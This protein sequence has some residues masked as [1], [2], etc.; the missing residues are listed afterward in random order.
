MVIDTQS[1]ANDRGLMDTQDVG[2]D[3]YRLTYVAVTVQ[4]GSLRC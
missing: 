1:V 4:T 2:L 3:C